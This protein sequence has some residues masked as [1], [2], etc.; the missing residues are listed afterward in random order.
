[1]NV[2][3][4]LLAC[5]S[6]LCLALLPAASAGASRPTKVHY[7]HKK[8]C[9]GDAPG[10]AQCKALVRTQ[11]DRVTPLATKGPTGYGPADLQAAYS[12]P[13]ASGAP[14]SGPLVAIVDAYDLPSAESDLNAYRSRYGLGACTT[15]NGCFRKVNQAGTT[16]YPRGNI[17]WGQEIALDIEMV[18]AICPTC[19]ILLVEATNNSFTNLAQGVNRAAQLGAVAI[20]NSYGAPESNSASLATSYN[21][22]GIA[23]TVSSGD[24]GYGVELPAAFNTVI[25]VGGTT[26]NKNS[27][28]GAF[29][30]TAWSGAGSGCSAYYAKPSWQSDPGCARRSVADVSAI[31]NP[32]TGVSVYDSY[33]SRKGNNWYVFGG[34]SVAAPIIA[35]VYG[36]A[37][38]SGT[39]SADAYPVVRAY[40][41][42]GQ[43][44][45]ITSGS[46]GS[47]SGSYL[48]N[49]GPGFDGPTGLGTPNGTGAF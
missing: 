36:L 37:G 16:N 41:N 43:L 3:A 13:A 40:Q 38:R 9:S 4:T 23:I 8:V 20:S 48:C 11:K 29:T 22:P 44:H 34:T 26:L 17:G 14:G 15:A 7:S 21:H 32:S 31:G 10:T 30:E 18:A 33:G 42:S 28:T 47:C 46:N 5:I 49:A 19:K 6:L 25:A 1:M 24:N 12:L 39:G 45:D 2:M 35:G 27:T